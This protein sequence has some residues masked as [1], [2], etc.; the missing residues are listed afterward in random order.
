M[1]TIDIYI[2]NTVFI[3]LWHII[4]N[5]YFQKTVILRLVFWHCPLGIYIKIQ[6][7][8][9]DEILDSEI[10]VCVCVCMVSTLEKS[11]VLGL[12]AEGKEHVRGSDG[13]TASPMQYTWTWANVRRWWGTRRPGM[14]P[15]T[16]W[17][18]VRHDWVTEQQQWLA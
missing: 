2:S 8:N 11:L 13:W 1:N 15:S 14:L 17:Q 10:Y 12:R 5:S 7:I 6:Y 3:S 18:R 16:G 4:F 9:Y